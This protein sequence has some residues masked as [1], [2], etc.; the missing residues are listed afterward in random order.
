MWERQT[1]RLPGRREGHS[2]SYPHGVSVP[3]P[4][5]RGEVRWEGELAVAGHRVGAVGLCRRHP[6]FAKITA[7]KPELCL[8]H[9]EAQTRTLLSADW[10][11]GDKHVT[12]QAPFQTAPALLRQSTP[13]TV[14]MTKGPLGLLGT[15]LQLQD[16]MP[17]W[18]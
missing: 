8:L 15:P 12:P 6:P 2:V 11:A 1:W 7:I 16:T 4:K 5:V 18:E 9:F 14:S 13:P 3:S 10:L 17:P